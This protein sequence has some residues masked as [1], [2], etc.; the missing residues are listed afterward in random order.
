MS[1]G[2][3]R[4]S[5]RLADVDTSSLQAMGYEVLS[6]NVSDLKSCLQA[7]QGMDTVIHLAA[8]ARPDADFHDSLLENNIKGC[9][10]LFQAASE[11]GCKRVIYASSLQ[12]FECYPVDMEITTDMPVLPKNAYGLS[13]C[14]GEDV[15]RLFAGKNG[16][17]CT[18]A[19]IGHFGEDSLLPGASSRDKRSYLSPAD[20]LRFFVACIEAETGNWAVVHAVSNNRLLRLSLDSARQLINYQPEDDAFENE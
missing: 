14:F 19:R 6:L 3:Q 16:L 8:D 7:C 18:V 13:K 15:A 9:Y 1:S 17:S 20:M 10:N 2:E 12:V 4:Y 11:A 5:L